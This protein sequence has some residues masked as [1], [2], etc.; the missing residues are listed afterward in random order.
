MVHLLDSEQL[1]AL[2]ADWLRLHRHGVDTSEAYDDL[3]QLLA[4]V[5]W[6]AIKEAERKAQRLRAREEHA[7]P[8]TPHVDLVVEE[9]TSDHER[10]VVAICHR[11]DVS[12]FPVP[13]R[14]KVSVHAGQLYLGIA[15]SKL[16]ERGTRESW[17]QVFAESTPVPQSTR[18]AIDWVRGVLRRAVLHELDECL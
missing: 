13:I 4:T 12:R 10:A 3:R 1:D 7:E 15:L 18:E 2:A 16:V 8:L 6:E 17:S 5:R 9:G 14:I 11:L